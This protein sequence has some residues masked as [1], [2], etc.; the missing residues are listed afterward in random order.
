YCVLR[1]SENDV[2]IVQS[3]RER[4]T[5]GRPVELSAYRDCRWSELQDNNGWQLNF[6]QLGGESSAHLGC[7]LTVFSFRHRRHCDDYLG[8]T[9]QIGADSISIRFAHRQRIRGGGNV[10]VDIDQNDC[11]VIYL[12]QFWPVAGPFDMDFFPGVI[13]PTKTLSLLNV[14]VVAWRIEAC[15]YCDSLRGCGCGRSA[16]KL[17]HL[18][19]SGS[20]YR[21]WRRGTCRHRVG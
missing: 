10:S 20:I 12:M 5:H 4:S 8:I 14:D 6:S 16:L 18:A 21:C 1:C 19:S 3:R 13:L 2:S 9:G 11:A 7:Y 17:S 15:R